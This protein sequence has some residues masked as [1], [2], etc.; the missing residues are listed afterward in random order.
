MAP[1]PNVVRSRS[2]TAGIGMTASAS[3]AQF[4]IK[5]D[6][7]TRTHRDER[8]TAIE[9]ARLLQQRIPGAKIVITDLRDGSVVSFDRSA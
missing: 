8:D 3:G 5:T 4:E 1:A 7:M 6:G 9:A 2:K